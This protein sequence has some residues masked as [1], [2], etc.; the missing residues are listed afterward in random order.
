[1]KG[2]S[3]AALEHCGVLMFFQNVVWLVVVMSCMSRKSDIVSIS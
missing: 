2:S 3:R 1:M